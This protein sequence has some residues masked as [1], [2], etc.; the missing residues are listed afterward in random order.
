MLNIGSDTRIY[1][2]NGSTDMRKGINGLSLLAE[3]ILSDQFCNG[4]MFVFRGRR[5]DRIK[6]LWWDGQGFVY[7]INVLIVVNSHG[8]AVNTQ[9]Q[10]VLPE[11]NYLC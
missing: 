11:V 7:S 2:Y 6:V 8:Q 9:A 1:L 3:S 5:A 10:L 4:A